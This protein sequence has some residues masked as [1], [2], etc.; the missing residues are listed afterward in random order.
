MA[1]FFC[2]AV[3]VTKQ[4]RLERIVRRQLRTYRLKSL[5]QNYKP[6]GIIGTYKVCITTVMP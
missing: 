6:L 5:A 4:V 1:S 3:A 2:H